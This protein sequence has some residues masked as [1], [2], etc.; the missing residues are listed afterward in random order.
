M[1]KENKPID[2]AGIERDFRAGVMSV[3]EIAKWYGVSHTGINKKAKAEGWAREQKAPH[4]ERPKAI[5]G[6]VIPPAASTAKPEEL[7][8]RA[9]IGRA[10]V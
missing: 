8:D 4:I 6:D 2:W 7:P 5:S 3:R 9:Q 1:P 10:H